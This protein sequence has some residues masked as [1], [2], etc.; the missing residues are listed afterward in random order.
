MLKSDLVTLL[1]DRAG[2]APRVAEDAVDHIFDTLKAALAR[3]EHIEIRGLGAFHVKEY[4]G[5]VG[6]NPK[7][8]AAINVK[9]KRG[10]LFRT[11][12]DLRERLNTAPLPADVE[13][14]EES[15]AT[16]HDPTEHAA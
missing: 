10:V 12:K 3:G 7:T 5:Y 14:G 11:G 15:P 8:S 13:K 2:L 1:I 4:K 9:P 6:R 16:G